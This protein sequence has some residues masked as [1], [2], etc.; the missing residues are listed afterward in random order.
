MGKSNKVLLEYVHQDLGNE[1]T[2]LAGYYVPLEEMRLEY[3]GREFLCVS[4][5]SVIENSCCGRGG[6]SYAIVP[7]YIVNW[8]SKKNESG[9]SITEVE[10]VTDAA[11][12][13]EISEA[14][15]RDKFYGSVEFW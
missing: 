6:C 5:I 14:L 12:K 2:A 13:K 1:V 3:R 7:G 15:K 8:Q 10:P 4:G 9:L 11:A